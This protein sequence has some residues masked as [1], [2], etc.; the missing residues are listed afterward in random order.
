MVNQWITT[1]HGRL[2]LTVLGGLAEFEAYLIRARTSEG[3]KR[4]VAN[5]VKLGRKPTLTPHQQHEAKR[6]AAQGVEAPQDPTPVEAMA[7]RLKTPA[8]RALYALR[9]TSSVCA[10]AASSACASAISTRRGRQ[11]GVAF[12]EAVL[13]L[14]G[15]AHRVDH[16]AKL[17]EA[18]V[19]GSLDDPPVVR[20]DGWIDQI[21]AQP[22]EP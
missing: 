7:H 16:A 13:H 18:A 8:G 21:A 14:N 2:I 4:A 3:R 1:A 19:P 6:R 10:S 5:G 17:D 22:P 20:V 15:A 9:L 11:A 12:N